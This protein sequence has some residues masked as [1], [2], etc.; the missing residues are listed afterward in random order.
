LETALNSP[1]ATDDSPP[2]YRSEELLFALGVA[3]WLAATIRWWP[4]ALSFSDE[5]GYVGQAK[6]LL[7]GHLRAGIGSPGM[8]NPSPTGP[9]AW[10]PLLVPLLLAPLF[11]VTPTAIFLIGILPALA[12]A[13]MSSRIFKSLG[14]S[15]VWG[16]VF[17][18][19]PTVVILSRTAMS[20][21]LLAAL[22]LGTWWTLRRHRAVPAIATCAV[23]MA[24]RPTGVPIAAAIIVGEAFETW[25]R[26]R[27]KTSVVWQM[28]VGALGFVLGSILVLVSNVLTTGTLRFGY[29]FRP[30]VPSFALGY[31]VTDAPAYLRALL[32]NPPLVLLGIVPLWRRRLWAPLLVV[33]GFGAMMCFYVWVDS[34]PGLFETLVLSERLILPIVT[35]LLI[36]YVAGLS[37]LVERFHLAQVATVVLVV[38]PT[39]IAFKLGQRHHAWQQPMALARG[40][41]AHLVKGLGTD[42]LGL[43]G[44]ATKAGL[45]FSG[46]TRWIVK[47]GPMPSVLLCAQHGSSFR[48]SGTAIADHDN[49]DQV[50]HPG[51]HPVVP[52]SGFVLMLRDGV[53]APPY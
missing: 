22:A 17:L 43:S 40:V 3:G 28:K 47:D 41:S 53:E 23:M 27:E 32:A 38:V 49:C 24:A 18:A 25:R 31:F 21:L 14:Q 51:Y 30:G 33:A 8:W 52:I 42:E 50:S 12:L 1:R 36:G 29:S 16:L 9:V 4:V 48:T 13:W 11:A 20:D 6:L 19:H 26:T 45:L 35:F 44:D 34:A 2:W 37:R 39:I 5:I 15:P 7:E 46:K 10:Y